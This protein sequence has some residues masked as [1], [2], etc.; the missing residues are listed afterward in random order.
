MST[1]EIHAEVI[2][3]IPFKID[4]EDWAEI[5]DDKRHWWNNISKGIHMVQSKYKISYEYSTPL[6]YFYFRSKNKI[7]NKLLASLRTYG[8][9]YESK[10][11]ANY[12]IKIAI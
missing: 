10:Y 8:Q 4:E 2:Q 6:I 5:S 9:T 3:D 11:G 12:V 7:Y 1:Q